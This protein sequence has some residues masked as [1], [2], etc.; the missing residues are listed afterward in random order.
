[1]SKKKRF[2][3]KTN[4]DKKTTLIG[5]IKQFDVRQVNTQRRKNG[6]ILVNFS[7]KCPI[8]EKKIRDIFKN[9]LQEI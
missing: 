7:V 1:M 5:F 4:Y 3:L 8:D 6:N 9:E 2:S